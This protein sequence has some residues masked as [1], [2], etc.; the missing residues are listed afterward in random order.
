MDLSHEHVRRRMLTEGPVG[1]WNTLP[2]THTALMYDFVRFAPDGTGETY[3]DSLLGGETFEH[4][5]WS[6]VAPGHLVCVV[7]EDS[8]E[9]AEPENVGFRFEE[10]NSDVGTFWVMRDP[11]WDGFWNFVQAVVPRRSR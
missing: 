6:V 7:V 4:F 2:G 1:E 8:E 5:T 11:D 10:Q 3:R 9:E